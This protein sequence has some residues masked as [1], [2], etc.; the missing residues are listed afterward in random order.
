MIKANTFTGGEVKD[1]T[2][3]EDSI[4]LSQCIFYGQVSVWNG[5]CVRHTGTRALVWN[6]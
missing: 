6:T 2:V 3:T 5:C 4:V 1:I